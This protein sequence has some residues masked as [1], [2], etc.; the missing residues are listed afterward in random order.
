[1]LNITRLTDSVQIDEPITQIYH[2]SDIHVRLHERID[3]YEKVF[4]TFFDQLEECEQPESSIILISGDIVHN[5][6]HLSPE[7]IL[8]VRNMFES[9]ASLLPVFIIMGNH[10]VNMTNEQRVDSLT[11]L[12]DNL[13]Y[14]NNIHYMKD[15]G[16]YEYRNL[17]FVVSSFL[18]TNKQIVSIDDVHST[19]EH[20]KQHIQNHQHE[21]YE[22]T[23]TI[24]LYHGLIN[25]T[26]TYTHTIESCN[27]TIKD[28]DGYDLFLLGDNHLQQFIRP[29]IAYAG[30]M[31]QQDFGEKSDKHGYILWKLNPHTYNVESKSIELYN[32]TGFRSIVVANDQIA[33]EH[34]FC[35]DILTFPPNVYLR[36]YLHNTTDEGIENVVKYIKNDRKI[37][38]LKLIHK[39]L[40][41]K[42]LIDQIGNNESG[43]YEL[44]H[45]QLV[46]LDYHNGKLIPEYM[47]AKEPDITDDELNE[48]TE[49]NCRLYQKLPDEFKATKNNSTYW[50][51]KHLTF[52][53]FFCYSE[54]M[55]ELNFE[56]KTG[57]TGIIASNRMGKSAI[58]DILLYA[59]FEKCSRGTLKDIISINTDSF[60]VRVVFE[61]GNVEYRIE[62][63]GTRKKNVVKFTKRGERG[64]DVLLHEQTK[65][66]TNKV[67]RE[68]V[69]TYDDFILTS[70]SLQNDIS[71]LIKMSNSERKQQLSKQLRLNIFEQLGLLI[72]E[73]HK[74][75]EYEIKRIR[76]ELL[77]FRKD[78][79]L[80]KLEEHEQ[81]I[82]QIDTH[83]THG[84]N[85]MKNINI[86]L[87]QYH[88]KIQATNEKIVTQTDLDT[89]VHQMDELSNKIDE[90]DVQTVKL[91]HALSNSTPSL[92]NIQKYIPTDQEEYDNEQYEHIKSNNEKLINQTLDV[93][94]RQFEQV[95]HKIEDMTKQLTR[96]T[97]PIKLN[98]RNMTVSNLKEKINELSIKSEQMN[99]QIETTSVQIEQLKTVN[100]QMEKRSVTYQHELNTYTNQSSD[101]QQTQQV[102]QLNTLIIETQVKLKHYEQLKQVSYNNTCFDCM[103]NPFVIEAIEFNQRNTNN[104]LIT[105]LSDQLTS[106]KMIMNNSVKQLDEC[107]SQLAENQTK[108]MRLYEQLNRLSNLRDTYTKQIITFTE[109][110]KQLET[111]ETQMCEY[112]QLNVSNKKIEHEIATI[113]TTKA[114]I[115]K[116]IAGINHYWHQITTLDSKITELDLKWQFLSTKHN[117]MEEQYK[118][119][120]QLNEYN[121]KLK[122]LIEQATINYNKVERTT[123]EYQRQRE[124]HERAK[125]ML[126]EQ[127]KHHNTQTAKLT[128]LQHAH[129]TLDRYKKM[130]SK[131]GIVYYVLIEQ[132]KRLEIL[133][134]SYLSDIVDFK[135]RMAMDDGKSIDINIVNPSLEVN[136]MMKQNKQSKQNKRQSKVTSTASTL[137]YPIEQGSGFEKFVSNLALKQGLLEIS[138]LSRANIF[139][140]DE[141]FGNFD[142][143]NLASV[144]NVF[145]YLRNKFEKVLIIS[146][147]EQLQDSIDNQINIVRDKKK[148]CSRIIDV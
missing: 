45:Q 27:V 32:E 84:K 55:N 25:N 137:D 114:K 101:E 98:T 47:S 29:H 105:Q 139:I 134:N 146:H 83:I 130:M 38:I 81:Q 43:T 22:Y 90:Y 95:E 40:N 9:L 123:N 127:L 87:N 118:K 50:K 100:V 86:K 106:Y 48:L 35:D 36:I 12:L 136:N 74:F 20:Y 77:G 37:N 10:D 11:A 119:T 19:L 116:Q 14:Q 92:K 73:E 39:P 46:S 143:E 58:V 112:Q 104:E 21:Q 4:N 131:E 65:N 62:R 68:I 82:G 135:L 125:Y 18:N 145:D 31:I 13:E 59:L 108:L 16:I 132:V 53:G 141:G 69:G 79:I 117:E 126:S 97:V 6:A 44:N 113:K 103:N 88:E 72:K 115:Q 147:I 144:K 2:I 57:I 3:E 148:Q 56:T 1:M 111:Y 133:A 51:I 109:L 120:Y 60:L 142:T 102:I 17:Q 128:Q 67:I 41:T 85:M 15:Q 107:N 28:F 99:K 5:K 7:L 140:V 33:N 89:I 8:C 96:L 121:T 76:N 54:G 52:S 49:L 70:V 34:P 94:Q 93:R 110:I 26:R 42:E 78:D 138:H 30:S 63:S 64:E 75:N 124:E 66:D 24:G 61:S 80:T 129:I 122:K 91:Y 23:Y 71:G